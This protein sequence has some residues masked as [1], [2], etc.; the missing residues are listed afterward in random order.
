MMKLNPDCIRDIMLFCEDH[1]YIISKEERLFFHTIDVGQMFQLSLQEKG[2]SFEDV[3]YHVIQLSEDG[4]IS[5]DFRFNGATETG[6]LYLTSIYYVTSKG[7]NFVSDIKE[8]TRWNKAKKTMGKVGGW[9]LNF[10]SSVAHDVMVAEVS[11]AL[12]QRG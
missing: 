9:S 6:R 3:V 7:Q 5:T 12:G 1:S 10:L 11:V 2:Y 8:N 4:Y